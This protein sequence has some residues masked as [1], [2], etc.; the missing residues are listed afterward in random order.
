[1]N[2]EDN[3]GDVVRKARK[4]SNVSPE[5]A[6]TAAGISV[7]ELSALVLDTE[8]PPAQNIDRGL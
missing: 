7:D 3:L 4:A 8:P 2:L 1:M 5:T 6:A